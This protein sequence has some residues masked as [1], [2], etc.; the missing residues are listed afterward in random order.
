MGKNAENIKYCHMPDEGVTSF[1]VDYVRIVWNEHLSFHQQKTWELTHVL[2]GKGI[3]IIGDTIE[4]FLQGEVVL[5]PP[6]IPHSWSYDET[7]FNENGEIENITIVFSD[8]LLSYLAMAFPELETIV[9]EIQNKKSAISFNGDTLE[10]LQKL[11]TLMVRETK[12]EQITSLVK[13][14]ALIVSQENSNIVGRP[15]VDDKQNKRLQQ[16]YWYVMNHFQQDITLEEIS[17]FVDME[18]TSFCSFFKKM[19]DKT[20]FTYLTEYRIE[21]SC[22]MLVKTDKSIADICYASGFRDIPHYNRVF[23]KLKKITPSVYRKSII[24]E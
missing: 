23:K 22:Q 13:I 24:Q 15:V 9:S 17:K 11:M 20:F 4:P 6:D 1:T 18:K 14:F 5:I 16:I 12:I 21:S 10:Q 2:I 3:R 8:K 19:T 7:T